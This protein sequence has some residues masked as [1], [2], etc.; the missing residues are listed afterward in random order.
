MPKRWVVLTCDGLA[1][2]ALGAYGSSWLET[3]AID[4]LAALGTVYD[5]VIITHDD[6]LETL[7]RFWS[8]RL[9]GS[10]AAECFLTAGPAAAD[11]SR[12]AEQKGFSQ[13]TIVE[14]IP[15]MTCPCVPAEDIES[16]AMGKL[17]VP[18]LERI[19]EPDDW[20][21]LW[22]HCDTL[23]R[24]WDAP[25]EWVAGDDSDNEGI[26]PPSDIGQWLM[27]DFEAASNPKAEVDP[28]DHSPPPFFDDCIVPRVAI[29]KDAHP[30]L[31]TS[32][33]DTYGLQVRALDQW[34]G[35]VAETIA[36]HGDDIAILLVGT[37]GFCL[38]QNGWVGH[39]AGPIRSP[40]IHVPVIVGDQHGYGIRMP[41]VRPLDGIVGELKT[42]DRATPAAWAMDD[43]DGRPSVP[44]ITPRATSVVTTGTWFYVREGDESRLFVKPDDRE[45]VNDI[46]DRCRDVVDEFEAGDGSQPST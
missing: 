26:E 13:C 10:G 14:A 36:A 28:I 44:T 24:I 30:D 29:P 5:R 46:A 11:L 21:T 16:T 20:S 32:W 18:L 39:R 8:D 37:S 27:E 2:S 9:A 45:D 31:I 25:S 1:I 15:D 43:D 34:I 33:M 23:V 38:G 22:V 41:G 19:A 4:A 40:Q 12:L 17:F 42:G 6:T 7:A 3:P 35:I